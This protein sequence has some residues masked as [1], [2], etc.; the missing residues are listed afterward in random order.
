MSDQTLS[1]T[2]RNPRQALCDSR[3]ARQSILWRCISRENRL[4]PQLPDVSADHL[5]DDT[6]RQTR[7][8]FFNLFHVRHSSSSRVVVIPVDGFFYSE[9]F[10]LVYDRQ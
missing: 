3:F 6:Q 2:D 1:T 7:D 8:W 4:P 10:I 5:H 9:R